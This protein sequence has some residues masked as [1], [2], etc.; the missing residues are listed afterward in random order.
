M[1]TTEYATVDELK[2]NLSIEDDD[3][4]DILD[5][6]LR[7]ASRAVDGHCRRR[8]WLD[9]DPTIRYFD[10]RS[11]VVVRVDDIGHATVTVATDDDESGAYAAAWGAG[12]F[13]LQPRNAGAESRPWTRLSVSSAGVRTFPLGPGLVKV[14]ARFGWPSVPAAVKDATL[15]QAARWYHRKDTPFAIADVAQSET[16]LRLFST[17]D[18]DV[19]VLLVEYRREAVLCA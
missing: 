2:A 10:A 4:D 19:V 14:T 7:S 5:R 18:P 3:E 13:T 16:A 17:L 6:V 11:R 8:F 1:A 9:D 12:D 15:L